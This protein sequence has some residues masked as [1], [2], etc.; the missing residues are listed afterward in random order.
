MKLLSAPYEVLVAPATPLLL[1]AL[2]VFLI[3]CWALAVSGKRSVSAGWITAALLLLAARG[4]L[5]VDSVAAAVV[6]CVA[7]VILLQALAATTPC[8]RRPVTPA[9]AWWGWCVIAAA[10][11]VKCV[12]LSTWPAHLNAYSAETAWAG[13]EATMGIWPQGLWRTQEVDLVNGGI[14][15]LHLP[16][17]WLSARLFGGNVFSARFAEVIGSTVLLI[18]TWLWL[19]RSV[20][21]IWSLVALAVF[22]FSPWHLAQSR[23]GTFQSISNALAI[24]MLWVAEIIVAGTARRRW[25]A[26]FGLLAGLIGYGYAPVKV[27][28][29][30]FAGI[31]ALAAFEARRRRRPGW[32]LGPVL[33]VLAFAVVLAVQ[34]GI[35]PDLSVLLGQ[36]YGPLATDTSVLHKTP[37]GG[38]TQERQGFAVVLENI[39]ANLIAGWRFHWV[40]PDILVWY[41]VALSAALPA[42]L[43]LLLRPEWRVASFFMLLG[44]L[45]PLLVYPLE[46][47]SLVLWPLV[48]VAGVLMVRELVRQCGALLDRGWWRRACHALAASCLIAA[49]L[50]GVHVYASTNSVVRTGTYFGPDHRLEMMQDAERRLAE[51]RVWF[52]NLT[53]E[54]KMVA[55]VRLFEEIRRSGDAERMRF[56]EV[57]EEGVI[58]GVGRDESHC[59]FLMREPNS[60]PGV[61]D[62]LALA[63]PGGAMLHRVRADG[64]G[65]AMYDVYS[66]PAVDGP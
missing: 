60:D 3:A 37:A 57:A 23:M 55:R 19:R 7:V 58:P 54:D 59:F 27:L 41:A 38:V 1:G 11:L 66:L 6:A 35:P 13:I 47:R 40:E 31:V 20:R 44:A 49:G 29:I 61:L 22:A 48:Y 42:A 24:A 2:A 9:P 28:Y 5:A 46:R 8:G 10:T 45:P 25:W 16:L 62:R 18:A 21:G 43:L 26:A 15:P 63:Y 51:C 64:S 52:I 36:E 17:M 33:S 12:E 50:H 32:W 4:C 14:S 53:F 34:L 39:S 65:E 30:F 56:V